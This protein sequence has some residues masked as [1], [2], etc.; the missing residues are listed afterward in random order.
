MYW[1][2][3]FLPSLGDAVYPKIMYGT[4]SSHSAQYAIGVVNFK[5]PMNGEPLG[6]PY[7][8]VYAY[9]FQ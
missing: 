8:F 1:H 9:P 6:A 5:T 3:I 7:R 2:I 4:G